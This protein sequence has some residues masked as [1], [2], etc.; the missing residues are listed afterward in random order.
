MPEALAEALAA[1]PVAKGAYGA[2]SYMR[3]KE[4]ARALAEAK[5][6]ETRQR[7]LAKILEELGGA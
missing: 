2:M 6:E 4:M 3:R 5:K 1:D 7:R